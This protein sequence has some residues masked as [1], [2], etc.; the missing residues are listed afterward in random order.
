MSALP[1]SST[2]NTQAI[3]PA[4]NEPVMAKPAANPSVSSIMQN[5]NIAVCTESLA[6][7]IALVSNV[8]APAATLKVITFPDGSIYTGETKNGHPHGKGTLQYASLDKKQRQKY[9]GE[10]SSGLPHGKG[11]MIWVVGDKYVGEWKNGKMHGNGKHT[12]AAG[13]TYEGAY[14]NNEPNGPGIMKWPHQ[15][16]TFERAEGTFNAGELWEGT[17][18]SVTIDKM[19]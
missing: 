9:E 14:K 10:F 13:K 17:R 6:L 15:A 5:S 3:P 16:G 18:S 7:P 19:K 1:V 8:A 11:T 12:S 4:A 2:N